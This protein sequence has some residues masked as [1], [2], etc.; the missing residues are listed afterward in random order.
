MDGAANWRRHK[1]AVR[2]HV[3]RRVALL[4][5]VLKD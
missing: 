4:G 3:G 5:Y 1:L 2:R